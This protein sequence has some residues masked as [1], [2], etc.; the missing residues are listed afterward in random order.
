MSSEAERRR[1]ARQRTLLGAKFV[2][3]QPALTIDCTIRDFTEH[4]ARIVFPALVAVPVHGWLVDVQAG[5]GYECQTIW[6]VAGMR[7]V[8]FLRTLDIRTPQPGW[9]NHLHRLWLVGSA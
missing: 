8:K 7:G 4:G 1:V 9:L 5:L 2:S 6:R 3:E